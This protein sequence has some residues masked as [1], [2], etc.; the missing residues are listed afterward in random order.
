MEG[1]L[2]VKVFISWS[3]ERSKAIALLLHEW[4]PNIIQAV[5]P[6]MSASD[7]DKGV[8][9]STDI[10]SQLEQT[11]FGII[12]LTP[13]NLEAPWILF[14]AGALSKTLDNTF[15]C[16]YLFGIE[17][18]NLKGP[19]VQFQAAKAQRE[20]TRKLVHT[21]NQALG[22]SALPEVTISKAFDIW[23][24]E[25]EK[26]LSSISMLKQKPGAQRTDRELLE[27]T[28]DLVRTQTRLTAASRW[29]E[30]GQYDSLDST[31]GL[32]EKYLFD[33]ENL[34]PET[35]LAL[36]ELFRVAYA[37]FSNEPTE[38]NKSS[39]KVSVKRSSKKKARRS[40]D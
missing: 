3:G 7:I 14:E 22:E 38:S 24:P 28:L 29:N 13:E 30:R 21:I 15:V 6:W 25:L 12:C 34:S 20:E 33:D 1:K 5:K 2:V 37:Q 17:P 27:E 9:W 10:A 16:P 32:V 8:R 4:L 26:R 23:W 35:A 36:A 31:P 18:S 11:R 40:K 19:L 39:K